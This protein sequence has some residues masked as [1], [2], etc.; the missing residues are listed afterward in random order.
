MKPVSLSEEMLGRSCRTGELVLD[1]F[2]GSGSTLLAAARLGLVARLVELDP[3]YCDVIRKR[4]TA[5]AKG[6]GQDPGPG[7]LE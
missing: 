6:A 7:A 3:G 5:W 1:P 4:W 2:G